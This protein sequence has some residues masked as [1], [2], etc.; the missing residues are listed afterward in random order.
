MEFP[1]HHMLSTQN[2]GEGDVRR[3]EIDNASD[4]VASHPEP[5]SE[6]NV[7]RLP[8]RA[9]VAAAMSVGRRVECI[10]DATLPTQRVTFVAKSVSRHRVATCRTLTLSFVRDIILE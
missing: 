3:G 6:I 4:R 2:Q 1:E 9:A 10:G 5:S 7:N 8:L